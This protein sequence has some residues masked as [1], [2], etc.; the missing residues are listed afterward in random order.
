MTGLRNGKSRS[1]LGLVVLLV[2]AGHL[3]PAV[4]VLQSGLL[5]F[6]R[7]PRLLLDHSVSLDLVKY[8]NTHKNT[9]LDIHL[10]Q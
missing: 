8:T 5:G 10:E 9:H 1:Y 2:P 3:H 4:A 6:L 7:F